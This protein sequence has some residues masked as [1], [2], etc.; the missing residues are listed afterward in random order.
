[1]SAEID[2][3]AAAVVGALTGG[4]VRPLLAPVDAVAEV[5]KDRIKARITRTAER[6]RRKKG[7]EVWQSTE[8]IAVRAFGE[9]ALTDDA[10]VQEY[11]A[12]VVAGA[13]ETT[14]NAHLLALVARLTPRHLRLHYL[15]YWGTACY[16]RTEE[17]PPGGW[18]S[19]YTRGQDALR[20]KYSTTPDSVGLTDELLLARCLDHLQREQLLIAVEHYD[21]VF[22]YQL[23]DFGVELFGAAL[24]FGDRTFGE[25]ANQDPS[26]LLF[27]PPLDFVSVARWDEYAADAMAREA[28]F[29]S[30]SEERSAVGDEAQPLF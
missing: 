20:T 23:T 10:V 30:A 7:D 13:N 16:L 26:T 21:D 27:D 18:R 8:R 17:D 15:L 1:M 22:A 25:L 9:A 14:D 11:L 5:W 12:G 19:M 4:S 29:A 28:G 6:A 3:V 24:G 2:V